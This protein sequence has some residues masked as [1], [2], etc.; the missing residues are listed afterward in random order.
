MK[1]KI[2]IIA[3]LLASLAGCAKMQ[4]PIEKKVVL[5]PVVVFEN[6]YTEEIPAGS[7]VQ[8][9]YKLYNADNMVFKVSYE[10]PVVMSNFSENG[11]GTLILKPLPDTENGTVITI[12]AKFE[13]KIIE[14]KKYII[15]RPNTATITHNIQIEKVYTN[16][17]TEYVKWYSSS[18]LPH[19]LSIDLAWSAAH[20]QH[21]EGA[22]MNKGETSGTFELGERDSVEPRQGYSPDL[23]LFRGVSENEFASFLENAIVS[24]EG[25][26]MTVYEKDKNIKYDIVL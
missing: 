25:K 10:A 22:S 20:S 26:T 8:L 1:S 2:I 18:V 15:T 17:N 7:E 14:Q 11:G 12:S 3:I 4:V 23:S 6:P 16:N 13:N 19:Y 9:D 24:N 21:F 5:P